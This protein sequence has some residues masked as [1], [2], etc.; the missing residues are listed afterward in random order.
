MTL[1]FVQIFFIILSTVIGFYI[2]NSFLPD[3]FIYGL[4]GAAM[5]F[6]GSVLLVF[7]EA[8]MRKVSV[9]NLSA[10]VFGLIFGLFMSWVLTSAM[11]LIPMDVRLFSGIQIA[12]TLIFCYLGMAISIRGKD[13]FNIVIPYV[14]LARQD[15][16]DEVV[17]LD[18][19]V[20]IDG[21]IADICATKFI[22]GRLVVP[23]FVLRELQQI[24]DSSDALKRNRGRR[25]L[26]I[27]N[28][29]QK[30]ENIN[31]KIEE[32]DFAEMTEVDAK[33]VKLAKMLNAKILTNDYNLNKVAQLQG[34]VVLNINEL[35]NALKP[36]V[37]PGEI[38]EV[39]IVKEGKE[40]NQGVA[41]LEDGTM[42]V[43]DNTRNLIGHTV[44]AVVTSVLQTSA[45]RM[46]FAKL[47]ASNGYHPGRPPN[48][49]AGLPGRQAGRPPLR[50]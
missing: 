30:N 46:I 10:A 17:L 39:K 25:G 7:S 13:E 8:R 49:R 18:T 3:R 29:L 40:A 6:V 16:S 11:K 20:I 4:I 24:A 27:L 21:R 12:L 26:D 47:G 48:G 38:M 23:K 32:E 31:V 5:A 45:G 43:V 37:L 15:Q 41:Y 14:R 35:A 34:V 44:A 36:V 2:S 50:R 28:K 19:S 9:R 22:S 1:L 42:I 33:I